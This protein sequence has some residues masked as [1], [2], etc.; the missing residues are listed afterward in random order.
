MNL[1]KGIVVTDKHYDYVLKIKK[2]LYGSKNASRTFFLYMR[3]KLLSLRYTQSMIDKCVFY[4]ETTIFF[5]Y[6]NDGIFLDVSLERIDLAVKEF[7]NVCKIEDKGDINDYLGV[8]FEKCQDGAIVLTQTHLIDQILQELQLSPEGTVKPT[9]A[10]STNILHRFKNEPSH[11]RDWHYRSIIGKLNFFEK[12]TRPDISYSSHQCA[13]F[14]QDL[15]KSHSDAVMHLGKYLAGTRNQGI[16][17]R[18]S[19]E[20]SFEVYADA[21]FAGQ[22][23]RLTANE[24]ESTAK[25]RIGYIIFFAGCPLIWSSKLQ[26]MVGLSTTECEY[27]ALSEALR[28]T[29]P[30]MDM[31][32]E[33]KSRDICTF[34]SVPKVYC[35]AF[36]DNSGALELARLPKMRPRTKH[37]NQIFHHFRAYVKSGIIKVYP[38]ESA[39]QLADAMTKPQEQNIFYPIRKK[40]MRW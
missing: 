18:P 25:S 34:S 16:K 3:D 19:R 32:E 26:T 7:S 6:V 20:S 22:W 23:N 8:H 10:A 36:E 2:N 5:A 39:H 40:I 9:P 29:L 12:S 31:I 4:R 28:D 38:I 27:M 35:K 30:L 13:R 15:K 37:L 11:D 33:M 21:D 1:P 24:D 17:I 14:S